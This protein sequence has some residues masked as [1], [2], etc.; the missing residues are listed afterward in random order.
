MPRKKAAPEGRETNADFV[1]RVMEFSKSGPLAQLFVI[2][3]IRRYA[4]ACADAPPE[5]MQTGFISGAQWKRCAQ[6]IHAEV[7]RHLGE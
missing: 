5:K 4:E 1:A 3:S 6:E 7:T 2:E